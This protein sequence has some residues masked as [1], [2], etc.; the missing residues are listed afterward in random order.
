MKKLEY[1]WPFKRYAGEA[2]QFDGDGM[3]IVY[4]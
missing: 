2:D 1:P 4:Y 3:Q